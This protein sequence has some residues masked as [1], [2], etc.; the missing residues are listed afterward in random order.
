MNYKRIHDQIIERAKVRTEIIGYKE[1]HH[2]IPKCLGGDN[3]EDNL[4]YLTA[5]EHFLIHKLLCILNPNHYGLAHALYLMCHMKNRLQE[6][7]IP[8]SR[9]Y[10]YIRE[11]AIDLMI[12]YKKLH[13]T[14]GN[15][16]GMYGKTHTREVRDK[17]SKI[18]TGN[19]YRLGILHT[20][21]SKLKISRTKIDNIKSGKTIVKKGHTFSE[22]HKLN[23]TKSIIAGYVNGRIS[24]FSGKSHTEEQKEKWSKNRK[25]TQTGDNNPNSRSLVHIESGKEFK[26]RKTASEHF[27]VSTYKIRTWLKEGTLQD[28]SN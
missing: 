21:E 25:G 5:R 13:P 4:V 8:S 1:R 14:S 22:D 20:D 3:S 18:Q 24:S 27:K 28:V 7:Y 10:S 15:K 26:S 23:L 2:I 16:N 9:E 6:R 17:I 12:E 11:N 19:T